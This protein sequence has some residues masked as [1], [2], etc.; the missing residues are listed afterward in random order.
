MNVR[1]VESTNVGA[2][3]VCVAPGLKMSS[4]P[5]WKLRPLAVYGPGVEDR[6]GVMLWSTGPGLILSVSC[7]VASCPISSVTVAVNE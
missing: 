4:A 2:T 5:G 3:N 1:V 6:F 7:W